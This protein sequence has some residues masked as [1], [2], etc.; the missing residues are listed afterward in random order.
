[1]VEVKTK[2]DSNGS[3]KAIKEWPE[4]KCYE[5]ISANKISHRVFKKDHCHND[6]RNEIAQ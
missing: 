1:M 3:Y 5:E 4:L 2:V 6:W